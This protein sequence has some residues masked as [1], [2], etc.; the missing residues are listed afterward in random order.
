MPDLL[1]ILLLIQFFHGMHHHFLITWLK[2]IKQLLLLSLLLLYIIPCLFI[3]CLFVLFGLGIEDDIHVGT[4]SNVDRI[5]LWIC[6]G[7]RD[8][9]HP[10]ARLYSWDDTQIS[11]RNTF[12]FF[13]F[14]F[15][16]CWHCVKYY[17][18]HP[19]WANSGNNWEQNCVLCF[20]LE[21]SQPKKSILQIE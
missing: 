5:R 17:Q 6:E 9:S 14:L 13:T 2:Y 7:C 16:R 8:G 15:F 20:R 3:L 11:P 12:I 10:F 19:Q 1:L 4:P 21:I 18:P